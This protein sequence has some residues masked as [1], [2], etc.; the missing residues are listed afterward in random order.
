MDNKIGTFQ[1]R[2]SI[3]KDKKKA[4]DLAMH[5]PLMAGSIG[6]AVMLLTLVFSK[7]LAVYSGASETSLQY[8]MQYQFWASALTR[9]L[10]CAA[11]PWALS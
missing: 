1:K 11:S 6:L 8:A 3:S 5:A 9:C 10:L 2:Y 4:E 7:Q